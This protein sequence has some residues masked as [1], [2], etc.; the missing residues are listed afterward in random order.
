MPLALDQRIGTVVWSPLA[1]GALSGKIRRGR[2][3]PEGT[4][5]SQLGLARAGDLEKLFNI[6]DVLDATAKELGKTAAQVAINWV[7]QRPTVSSVIIGARNEKQLRENLGAT[8]WRLSEDHVARLDAASETRPSYP[9]W[10]QRL[11][12]RLNPPPVPLRN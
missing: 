5:S 2:P 1:G 4:R 10:H 7:L 8:G 3:V 9:Y 12:P 11:N 6:V